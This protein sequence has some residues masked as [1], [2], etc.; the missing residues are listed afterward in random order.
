M[1]K[2]AADENFNNTILRGLL[3]REP[4][5]DIVRLQDVGLTGA[6]DPDVLA[7]AAAE[8]RIVLSHDVATLPKFAYARLEAR[9]PMPGI[10][11]ASYDATR[12]SVIEDI[13]VLATCSFE[14]EWDG[15]V[16][17]LPL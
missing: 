3:R 8:Q 2:L 4:D 5:L 9:Q 10:F 11:I 15:Q 16:L 6:D 7:W 14:H 12:G 17:Y 1:L 13:L